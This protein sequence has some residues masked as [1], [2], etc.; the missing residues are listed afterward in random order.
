MA[1]RVDASLPMTGPV[2]PSGR[3]LLRGAEL[4]FERR[5]AD[6]ELIALDA[7]GEDRDRAAEANARRAVADPGAVA[8][9]GDFHSS[10]VMRTAAILSSAGML[11]VAPGVTFTG[12]RGATLVRLTP[13][14]RML[15]DAI[16]G[17]VADTGI[18]AL[19]VVHDHDDDYGV[20]VGRMCADAAARRGID[21]RSRP[22]W[23]HDE[24]TGSDIAGMGAVLYVG[25][26]G[27]GAIGLWNGLHELDPDLWLLGTEGIALP[28]LAHE[29]SP[30]AAERTRFFEGRRA[31]WG[32]YGFEAAALILDAAA[33]ANGDRA[34]AVRFARGAR[35][36]DSVIGRYSLDEQGLTTSTACGRYAVADGHLVWDRASGGA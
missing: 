17:W 5:G 4:A 10:Q 36:R 28:W 16:A 9:L 14:D 34:S 8:Y 26:A 21:T 12:L 25:V 15:A 20:P 18:R 11:Q 1:P 31:S 35:D 19:L 2:A 27:S 6:A 7:W 13:D 3:E 23:G 22:V 33:Q 32:L 30:G 29:I 24:P